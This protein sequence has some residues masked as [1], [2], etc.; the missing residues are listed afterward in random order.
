MPAKQICC[1][2]AQKSLS[3]T[4]FSTIDKKLPPYKKKKRM[5]YVSNTVPLPFIHVFFLLGKLPAKEEDG[6]RQQPIHG[7]WLRKGGMDTTDQK[8][9]IRA[10]RRVS[11]FRFIFPA[12]A[13]WG[14]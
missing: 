13:Q 9:L 7:P 3:G 1:S 11:S 10:W 6:H 5:L 2:S 14:K 12:T 8:L 4:Y